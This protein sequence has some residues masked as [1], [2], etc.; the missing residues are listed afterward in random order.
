VLKSCFLYSVGAE[1][2][3]HAGH[4]LD[5]PVLGYLVCFFIFRLLLGIYILTYGMR[6]VLCNQTVM[7]FIVRI[8]T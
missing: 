6:I 3:P 7:F 4:E 2:G 1:G 8:S 5:V